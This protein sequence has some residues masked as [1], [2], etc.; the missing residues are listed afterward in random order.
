MCVEIVA[1]SVGE[2]DALPRHAPDMLDEQLRSNIPREHVSHMR[3][4]VGGVGEVAA[5]EETVAQLLAQ[6]L[7]L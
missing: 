4:R 3:E 6:F 7:T 2:G 1:D 5:C